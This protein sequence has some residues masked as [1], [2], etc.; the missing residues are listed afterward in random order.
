MDFVARFEDLLAE[1]LD[2]AACCE[3]PLDELSQRLVRLAEEERVRPFALG[4]EMIDDE[5]H[6]AERAK[7]ALDDARFAVYAFVDEKMLNAPREDAALWTAQSLQWRYFQ[8]SQA[9]SMFFTLLDNLLAELKVPTSEHGVQLD[10]AQRLE[11][12][13][14]L[15]KQSVGYGVLSVF[16]LCLL[17]GFQGRLYDQEALLANIRKSCWHII[18]HQELELNAPWLNKS[19]QKFTPNIWS[20]LER[21]SY[22]IMPILVCILFWCLCANILADFAGPNI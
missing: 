4:S 7:L 14:K 11:W 1:G 10:L 13:V 18:R 6:D 16:A 20:S 12:A 2:A 17:Y 3:V 19:I 8:T 21:A 15:N 9:G 22:I 5:A